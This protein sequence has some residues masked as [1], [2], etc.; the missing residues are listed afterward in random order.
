MTTKSESATE[1]KLWKK[2]EVTSE[3]KILDGCLVKK[4]GDS[5]L[6]PILGEDYRANITEHKIMDAEG[7]LVDE[8]DKTLLILTYLTNC[9]DE[10]VEDEWVGGKS[11][12]NGMVFFKGGHSL[13]TKD[14]IEKFGDN[15]EGFHAAAKALNGDPTDDGDAAYRF[16]LLPK[17]PIK[18]IMW[19]KDNEFE[20][21]ASILFDKTIEDMFMLDVVLDSANILVD[22]LITA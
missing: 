13:P 22:K 20:A 6:V 11:L 14:L 18:V 19:F 5:L 17:V 12:K 8:F 16:H 4:E 21:S 1:K 10:D 9:T 2:L 7:S 3:E 15:E